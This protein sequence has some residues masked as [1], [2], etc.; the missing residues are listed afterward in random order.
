MPE[1]YFIIV[2]YNA[3]KWAEKSFTSLRQSS[4]PVHCIVVDNGSTDGTQKYITSNFPEVELIQSEKNLGFGKANNIGI[5]KAYQKGADFFYLMN[6]DAWIFNDSVEKL[7]N[8]YNLHPDKKEI[9]ILSPMH[10]DG[11]GNKLDIF[12][13]KYIAH[14]FETRLISDLYFQ[15]LQPFYEISFIN[16]AHWFLPKETIEIIGGFNPYFFHYGEDLEYVNRILFHKKK[17]FLVPESK[18][19]HDG[20]QSLSK[21]D[22]TKYEDLRIETNIMNPSIP[23]SLKAEKKALKQS[24]LKN[25]LTG[26]LKVYK[27]LHKKYHKILKEEKILTELRNKVKEVGLT[28]LNV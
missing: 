23:D 11:T 27:T 7:L 20:K 17:T 21:V 5:E 26:N 2:T 28:F 24:M 4:V 8:V 14:N 1:I 19:I 15:T 9:G 22:Y 6:Q 18:V 10:I 12:L 13:D 25:M 3:M 16:A